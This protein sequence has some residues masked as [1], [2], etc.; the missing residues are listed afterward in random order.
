MKKTRIVRKTSLW[1]LQ[2]TNEGNCT[3]HGYT[4]DFFDGKPAKEIREFDIDLATELSIVNNLHILHLRKSVRPKNEFI[5][6]LQYERDEIYK[7][8]LSR[9]HFV[10]LLFSLV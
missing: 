3:W 9:I 8:N 7:V 1:K 5:Q 6:P 2:K 10:W 4:K